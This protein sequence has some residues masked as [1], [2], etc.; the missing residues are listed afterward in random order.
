M[1]KL[2]LLFASISLLAGMVLV[3]LP[4]PVLAANNS[5]ALCDGSGG[6]WT[7]NDKLPNGG[8]CSSS[9]GRTVIGT[10]QQL[11]DVLVFLVGAIAVIM[12]II[13]GLRYVMSA[14]DQ[15]G[16]TGAKNTILYSIIGIVV[17]F[18]AYAIV[19]FVFAAFNIK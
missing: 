4:A 17:A 14:G 18:T 19:H 3:S 10:I 12:L 1:K 5:A 7:A 2:T 8:S 9:D 6:T 11:T 13:G 16:T 15:A